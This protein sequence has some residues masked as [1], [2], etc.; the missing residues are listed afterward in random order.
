[1]ERIESELRFRSI[2]RGERGMVFNDFSGHAASGARYNVLHAAWCR[3]LDRSS[4]SVPKVWFEDLATAID[5]LIRER[6]VEGR[7]WRRCGTCH[8]RGTAGPVERRSPVSDP[9]NPPILIVAM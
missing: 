1:M 8:A 6:G 3:W 9:P 7:A 4:P 2:L 5:W